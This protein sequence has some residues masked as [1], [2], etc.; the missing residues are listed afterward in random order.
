MPKG[1]YYEILRN[2]IANGAALDLN[3]P[4][5]TGIQL[6]P[7]N[8]IIQQIGGRQQIRVVAT[9]ADGRTRD[10]TREAFLE[11]GNTEVADTNRRMVM[12]FF[13]LSFVH[14]LVLGWAISIA[15]TGFSIIVPKTGPYFV[16]SIVALGLALPSSP[17]FIGTYQWLTERA[18]TVYG[19][20]KD[21]SRSFS[22]VFQLIS[23]L[24]TTIIGFLFFL[25]EHMTWKELKRTEEEIKLDEPKREE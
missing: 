12:I 24:P 7:K 15:L 22:S 11:S 18:L 14:W 19:V 3:T 13:A 2:W 4:R 9:Y 25:R 6:C 1:Q 8:P 5:V 10:V 16:L 21:L 20:S 23:F 17:A